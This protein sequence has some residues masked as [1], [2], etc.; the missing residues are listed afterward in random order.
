MGFELVLI[1]YDRYLASSSKS[2]AF[3]IIYLK[4]PKVTTAHS[5]MGPDDHDEFKEYSCANIVAQAVDFR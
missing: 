3:L 4:K 2:F 1:L 5:G